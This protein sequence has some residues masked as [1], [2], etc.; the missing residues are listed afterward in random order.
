MVTRGSCSKRLR[1]FAGSFL[2]V[3]EI[4]ADGV[5]A[6]QAVNREDAQ[7]AEVGN[8]HRPVEPRQLMDAGE[9]VV[10][11]ALASNGKL[12]NWPKAQAMDARRT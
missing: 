6:V 4:S 10:E 7:D 2:A 12:R 11:H 5:E 3:L 1:R 9:G 8:Q